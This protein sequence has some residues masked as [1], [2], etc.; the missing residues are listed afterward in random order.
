MRVLVGSQAARQHFPDFRR[1]NDTDYFSDEKI[2]GAEV[3]YDPRLELWEWGDVATP[4]ELY[5]IK[6]SHAFWANRWPKHIQDI[7]WMQE[8]GCKR[9]PEL[10]V[11]LYGIWTDH[12]G[13]KKARLPKG[14]TADT[15]F[16]STVQRKYDHDSVHASIAYYDRPLFNEILVDGEQV[17]VSRAKFEQLDYIDKLRLAREEVY[18]TALERIII[19]ADYRESPLRAYR[20]ALEKT[21]T[22]F[23]KGWFPLFMVENIRYLL[24]PEI[25]YV[26][27]HKANA[28][29]LI[30]LED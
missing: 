5:T 14:A 4:D 7:A 21:V 1:P 6:V 19:P 16:T 13:K 22:S 23:S 18:A 30:L 25:D 20:W 28:D 9:I 2:E 26:S 15:F 11:L 10:H 3:F 12:Y 24:K 29:K 17:A 27:R 8:R